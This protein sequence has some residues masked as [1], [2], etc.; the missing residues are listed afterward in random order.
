MKI[1]CT[2]DELKK[3]IC[4][5]SVIQLSKDGIEWN[6]KGPNKGDGKCG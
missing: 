3:L 4:T 2:V 6:V 5:E 1:E